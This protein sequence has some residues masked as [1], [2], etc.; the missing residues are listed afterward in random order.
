MERNL[1]FATS[2]KALTLN[3][4]CDF[5]KME[6]EGIRM[7]RP[8][9][10]NK[11][12]QLSFRLRFIVDPV[13]MTIYGIP[14]R[15]KADGT[16]HFRK[17]EINKTRMYDLSKLNDAMEFHVIKHAPYIKDTPL[18]NMGVKQWLM[19]FDPEADAEKGIQKTN[20]AFKAYEYVNAL[21]EE[22]LKDFAR[23]F[24]IATDT[25]SVKVIK[26]ILLE[27]CMKQPTS[28]MEK[29]TGDTNATV[30][31]II[32]RRCI[33]N[34]IIKENPEL[35][36]MLING[37]ILGTSE[38][39]VIQR[40]SK[41]ISLLQQ[42]DKESM[43]AEKEKLGKRKASQKD[44]EFAKLSFNNPDFDADAKEPEDPGTAVN[45][46]ELVKE[47]KAKG[48]KTAKPDLL[49]KNPEDEPFE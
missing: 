12:K 49:P 47:V 26:N 7:I 28:I 42:L 38:K 30:A 33:D 15:K 9:K 35:G 22:K 25:N 31:E 8:V 17:I 34:G 36:Y 18:P 4:L 23:L 11:H 48:S 43:Q 13:T 19:I 40:L 21:S 14:D 39:A 6:R 2:D 44:R 1:E 37:T 46:A 32:I 45:P 16:L 41:E 3:R 5:N 20:I 24:K 10:D 27:K 29:I